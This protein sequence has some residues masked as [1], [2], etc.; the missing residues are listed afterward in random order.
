LGT[1]ADITHEALYIGVDF[2]EFA[3][4][5]GLKPV[6]KLL[7]DIWDASQKVDVSLMLHITLGHYFS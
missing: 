5:P 3:P 7:L 4:V 2:L 1:A 6:A